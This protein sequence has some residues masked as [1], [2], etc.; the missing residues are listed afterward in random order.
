MEEG[1]NRE[2]IGETMKRLGM[3]ALID[4]AG[5]P[6]DSRQVQEPR[7]N[8]YIFWKAED[9]EGGWDRDINDFRKRHQR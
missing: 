4:A 7:H 5:V 1:K 3:S 6:V 9:V 2:R 8:P